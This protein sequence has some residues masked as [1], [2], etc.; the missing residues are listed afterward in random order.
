VLS[1]RA[2]LELVRETPFRR[3]YFTRLAGQTSDGVFQVALAS[4]VFFNPEKATTAGA[5][6]QFFAV[7]LL[8]YSLV[9]PFAGVFLDRW[10]RQRVLLTVNVLRAALV[11]VVA[12]E[13]GAGID[14]ALF[15]V[16]ALAVLSVNR[17]VLAGLSA[18]LPHVVDRRAL[19]LA[20]AVSTTSGTLAAG[21]GG[22][23][24][25]LVRSAAGSSAWVLVCA[26]AGYLGA[27]ALANRLR[28]D[29]LGPDFEAEPL[30]TREAL[31]HVLGG[32]RDGA[33]HVWSHRRAGHA[34]VAIA[35][36]RFFY[37][38][39]T[40]ATVLLYR[41]YF[42]NDSDTDAA[43]GGL[44]LIFLASGM[45]VLLAAVITPA[46]TRR[47]G[48]ERWIVLLFGLAAVVEVVCGFPF[49]QWTFVIAAFVLGMVAQGSKICVDTIVQR[50]V[51]Q[52][53][54][55]RVFSFYD[56]L[57]NVAFV[58]AAALGAVV[59]PS[60]GKSYGVVTTIAVGYA[61]TALGYATVAARNVRRTAVLA[62]TQITG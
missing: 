27:A 55:G 9:G 54:R 52:A 42:H 3:L 43:M 26:A 37:G 62:E 14:N 31:R 34:L 61:L 24:G 2:P 47:T 59:L 49:L 44:A 19:I 28:P 45:G 18:G 15:Y 57:F 39:S 29:E 50:G 4:Y 48:E 6:A 8:P 17:F 13:I 30:E 22:A 20:N 53:Y 35:S 5:A 12:A 56:V 10:R 51:D 38:L 46:V 33:R 16:S 41:N 36:H 25:Y 32:L 11:L 40:I 7:L 58:A 1:G 60:N 23:I 21:V